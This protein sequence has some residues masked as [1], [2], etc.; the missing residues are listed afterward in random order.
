MAAL[1][2]HRLAQRLT[3]EQVVAEINRVEDGGVAPAMGGEPAFGRVVLAILFLRP[4][5]G[6]DEFRRQRDDLVVSWRHQGRRQHGVVIFRLALAS[7]PRRAAWAW[8]GL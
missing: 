3:R 7:G 6:G 4:V 8:I 5:L 2:Q 1:V